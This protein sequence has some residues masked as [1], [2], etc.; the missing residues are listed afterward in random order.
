MVIST[1][2]FIY[3]SVEDDL[4]VLRSASDLLE[5]GGAMFVDF[6]NKKPWRQNTDIHEYTRQEVDYLRGQL[7]GA[8]VRRLCGVPTRLLRG[9]FKTL[10]FNLPATPCVRWALSLRR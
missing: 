2:A 10:L 3:Y 9:P 8:T 5:P 6:H 4:R 1:D 7:P